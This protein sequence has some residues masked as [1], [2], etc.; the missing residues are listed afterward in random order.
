MDDVHDSVRSV[1][2]RRKNGKKPTNKKHTVSDIPDLSPG[3]QAEPGE[4]ENIRSISQ[5][6]VKWASLVWMAE[7][8]S[9]SHSRR[10]S[11]ISTDCEMRERKNHF[12]AYRLFLTMLFQ[13][14]GKPLWK[15]D[16]LEPVNLIG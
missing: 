9:G 4:K 15:R 13:V 11:S 1:W 10:F 12:R 3:K 5:N 14:F 16:I 8:T 7:R 6:F 2:A